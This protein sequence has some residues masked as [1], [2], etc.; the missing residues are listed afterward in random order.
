[1]LLIAHRPELV[2]RADRVVPL[3]GGVGWPAGRPGRREP[4]A[5]ALRRLSAV[6]RA[7]RGRGAVLLG[8]LTVL[9][10]VGLMA[11]AGYLISRAAQRPAIL[12]LEGVIVAVRFFGLGRPLLRYLERLW[13][14]DL[15]LGVLGGVRVSVYERLEPLAPAQLAGYRNGDLL[16]R[17]VADVDALA[18]PLPARAGAPRWWRCSPV[19]SRSASRAAFLPAAGAV[20]AAGLAG[21]RVAGAGARRPDGARTAR[22][23]GPRRAVGRGRSSCS[24]APRSSS[25]RRRRNGLA[26]ARP[27]PGAG[28]LEPRDALAGGAGE[29]LCSG[30]RGAT[31]AGV[32][33]VSVGARRGG[34]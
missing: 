8:A 27:R 17:M 25:S 26:Q 14:H 12:S 18:E 21:R 4:D 29:G 20:L 13:S 31:V 19:P 34:A 28:A 6:A 24:R 32:L 11:S 5:S 3:E 9:F 23:S 10:G 2:A 30:H 16:A 33:A 7:P 1:M 22:G 15:A